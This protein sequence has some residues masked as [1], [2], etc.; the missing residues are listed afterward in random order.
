MLDKIEL[1]L[2]CFFS[3]VWGVDLLHLFLIS[4]YGT[5]YE[6]ESEN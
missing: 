1:G 4:Y 3:A 2:C 5:L 6:S